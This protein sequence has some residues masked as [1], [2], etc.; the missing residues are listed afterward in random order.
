MA[1]HQSSSINLK[2]TRSK[3]WDWQMWEIGLLN[4][5]GPLSPSVLRQVWQPNRSIAFVCELS[6]NT[7]NFLS[8]LK[9]LHITQQPCQRKS[10]SQS[11]SSQ[12]LKRPVLPLIGCSQQFRVRCSLFWLIE[13]TGIRLT[14]L[15]VT[16]YFLTRFI[17]T[18]NTS[19]Q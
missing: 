4:L 9:L 11:L 19:T 18:T 17:L 5:L 1:V 3:V 10:H 15:L 8:I 13:S 6:V 7:P 2:W 12:K 14:W 16:S